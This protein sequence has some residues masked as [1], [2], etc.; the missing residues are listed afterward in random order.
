MFCL[1]FE[2]AI[3]TASYSSGRAQSVPLVVAS[4]NTAQAH[5]SA[6]TASREEGVKCTEQHLNPHS[7]PCPRDYEIF[8]LTHLP[9]VESR[10]DGAH[11]C[12][13]TMVM[14]NLGKIL[15]V[16][17]QHS[18]TDRWPFYFDA[19]GM[20]SLPLYR[21]DLVLKELVVYNIW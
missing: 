2:E 7:T 9:R 14:N 15:V 16:D 1:K 18:R 12:Y 3:S 6:I 21:D 4:S 13:M 17:G 11:C 10:K 20:K 19:T 5:T 8:P